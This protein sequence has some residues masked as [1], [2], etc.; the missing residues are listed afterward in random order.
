MI[1][2]SLQVEPCPPE[3]REAA[4]EVLYQRIPDSLRPRL[5]AEVLHEASSGQIDLTG[6]WIARKQTW[7]FK[8]RCANGRII[9][10]LLTQALAGRA[11]AVW[12]LRYVP[13]FRRRSDRCYTCTF[14]AC[15][16]SSAEDSG[17]FRL[18]LMNQPATM[19]P[20]T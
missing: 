14:S 2:W 9:G 8:A 1:R 12:R 13:S 3:A 11:A 5:V 16:P 17:S 20:A 18:Y 6:L 15:Q 10:A 19:V 4:L 7:T